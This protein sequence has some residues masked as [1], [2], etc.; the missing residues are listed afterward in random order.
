[1]SNYPVTLSTGLESAGWRRFV[2]PYAMPVGGVGYLHTVRGLAVIATC[3]EHDGRRWLHVSVSCKSKALP[4]WDQL[5]FVK[6]TV[7]GTHGYSYQVFPPAT[8]HRSLAEVSHLW[9]LADGAPALPDFF[10][11]LPKGLI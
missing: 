9:A 6:D 2:A 5:R 1:M 4:T 11:R 3:E 8:D 10:A 7:I